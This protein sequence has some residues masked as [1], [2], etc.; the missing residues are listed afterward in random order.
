MKHLCDCTRYNY[1]SCDSVD[2]C[3]APQL[4]L[5][6]S[7]FGFRTAMR[8]LLL[9]GIRTTKLVAHMSKVTY[10]LPPS[11]SRFWLS[12]VEVA[13]YN[14]SCEAVEQLCY[15]PGSHQLAVIQVSRLK[16]SAARNCAY[17]SLH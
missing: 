11:E 6:L 17:F 10:V 1:M 8:G 9:H 16:L 15:M 14:R 3:I 5:N 4:Y 2:Q 12:Q 13:S 7:S